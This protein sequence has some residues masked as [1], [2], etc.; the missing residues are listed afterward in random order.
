MD[1]PIDDSTLNAS[2]A[3]GSVESPTQ[4]EQDAMDLQT[5]GSVRQISPAPFIA[6]TVYSLRGPT[7]AKSRKVKA[8]IEKRGTKLPQDEEASDVAE[9]ARLVC[10]SLNKATRHKRQ[11]PPRAAKPASL[12]QG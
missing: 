1:F 5:D 12:N 4:Q 7:Q 8:G 10:K 9:G 6:P 11:N 3:I 2:P